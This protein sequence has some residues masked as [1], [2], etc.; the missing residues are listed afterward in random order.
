MHWHMCWRITLW[1][2]PYLL[3][4][5]RSERGSQYRQ[6]GIIRRKVWF[7]LNEMQVVSGD[8][9][10][11]DIRRLSFVQ[12]AQQFGFSIG[13]I[14]KQFESLPAGRPPTK[15][16]WTKISHS[17]RIELDE[18]IE[19]LANLRDKLDGCIGCG[20]L[21]LENCSLYNHEDRA[22]SLG[23]GLRYLMGDKP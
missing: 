21:S 12:I 15:D 9:L 20:C 2:A 10:R 11:S 17:F 5:C 13:Q 23:A 8:F 18:R 19:T 1:K 16:D 6:Y 7:R 3:V 22:A 4:G 14:R